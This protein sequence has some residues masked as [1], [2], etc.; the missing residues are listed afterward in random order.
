LRLIFQSWGS[1]VPP[2][3]EPGSKGCCMGACTCQPIV[4]QCGL[5]FVASV[6]VCEQTSVPA[7]LLHVP[8]VH[9]CNRDA[10][11]HGRCAC[12]RAVHPLDVSC[13]RTAPAPSCVPLSFIPP[14]PALPRLAPPR[15]AAAGALQDGHTRRSLNAET[16]ASLAVACGFEGTHYVQAQKI[17]TRAEAH[18]RWEHLR[19]AAVGCGGSCGGRW[20]PP[21]PARQPAPTH[22]PTLNL[23]CRRIPRR[24]AGARLPAVISSSL[25]PCPAPLRLSDPRRWLAACLVRLLEC[26][27]LAGRATK[28]CASFTACMQHCIPPQLMCS[29]ESCCCHPLLACLQI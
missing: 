3:R 27:M 14:R 25:P 21:G 18:F 13:L 19:E 23:P 10:Q 15:P 24:P 20:A 6:F 29:V 11:Q 5:L 2:T 4:Q 17:R 12:A 8:Q 9:Y 7:L 22:P 26:C 16:R 1:S 28:L